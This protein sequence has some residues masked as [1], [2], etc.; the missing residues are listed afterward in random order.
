MYHKMTALVRWRKHD[1]P[2]VVFVS[3]AQITGVAV[4]VNPHFSLVSSLAFICA[5]LLITCVYLPGYLPGVVP[6]RL[7]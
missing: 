2:T 7:D 5:L 4:E 6:T 3:F 1:Y